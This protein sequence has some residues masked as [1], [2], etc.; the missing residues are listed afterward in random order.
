MDRSKGACTEAMIK[1]LSSRDTKIIVRIMG[2]RASYRDRG[3]LNR[4]TS[5][6]NG[7]EL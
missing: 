6:Q 2:I 5:L 3:F 4:Y 7:I 1:K